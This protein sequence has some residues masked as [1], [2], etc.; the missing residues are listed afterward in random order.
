M[1]FS[2]TEQERMI[3]NTARDFA[4]KELAPVALEANEKGF[5]PAEIYGKLAELGFLGITVPETYGGVA[6]DTF[7]L[8]L[9]IEE[10]AAV[11]ASTAV[12]LSVH[13]SLTNWCILHYG[14]EDARARYLPRLA[15]GEILGA[16]AITESEAGSDVAAMRMTAVRNGDE[17]VLNGA[18]MFISTGDRA[19][20]VIVFARTDP[21]DR[22]RGISA[23]VVDSSAS[24]FSVGKDDY[25]D[26]TDVPEQYL[27][28]HCRSRAAARSGP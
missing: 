25:A 21:S 26:Y 24:G 7:S 2:L 17:Y 22:T 6:L 15:S 1:K 4:R 23:F 14:S 5:F 8:M 9:V 10:I 20:V 3:Q 16:Y 13:N 12:T 27:P 11:C 19:G 28:A 18:K